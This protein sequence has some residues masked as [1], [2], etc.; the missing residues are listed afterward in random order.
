M[1]NPIERPHSKRRDVRR[2]RDEWHPSNSLASFDLIEGPAW[3]WLE[4]N[5]S[6]RGLCMCLFKANL[7]MNS[8][9]LWKKEQ[10]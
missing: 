10:K 6:L 3:A 2:M 7:G 4:Y 1:K 9:E 8:G 5:E